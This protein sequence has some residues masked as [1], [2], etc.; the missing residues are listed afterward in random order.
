MGEEKGIRKE[1]VWA[2]F[3]L[4]LF[5]FLIVICLY[6]PMFK[7]GAV[8]ENAEN[9]AKEKETLSYAEKKIILDSLMEGRRN[10]APSLIS[11]ASA[12]EKES[13]MESAAREESRPSD[14]IS[15]NEK[16]SILEAL[17]KARK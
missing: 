17:M 11:I 4:V 1:Y 3:W 7:N 6:F 10:Y 12:T 16:R 9:I 5:V 8:T 2:G 15:M 14:T 13:V